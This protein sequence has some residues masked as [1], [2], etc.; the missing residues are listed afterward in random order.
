MAQGTCS[1]VWLGL[2]GAQADGR[3]KRKGISEPGKESKFSKMKIGGRFHLFG[4]RLTTSS[5][6]STSGAINQVF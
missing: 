1:R 6:S 3:A 2:L 4:V 5:S